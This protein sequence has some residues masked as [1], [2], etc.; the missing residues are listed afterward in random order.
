MRYEDAAWRPH[1]DVEAIFAS[2]SE[3]AIC[4]ALAGAALKDDDAAWIESR[5]VMLA[6]SQSVAIRGL[7]ATCLGHVAR[8]FGRIQPESV[9]L[10]RRLSADPEVGGLADDALDDVATFADP[11]V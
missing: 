2:G 7:A 4:D 11:P 9:A 1:D 6:E 8:R 10:L 5:C 3:E